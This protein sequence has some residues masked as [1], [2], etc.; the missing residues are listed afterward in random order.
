[1]VKTKWE[2]GDLGMGID[3][4]ARHPSEPSGTAEAKIKLE[5]AVRSCMRCMR[6][7]H[8]FM[9]WMLRKASE[10]QSRTEEKIPNFPPVVFLMFSDYN[11]NKER[12]VLY[13]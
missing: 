2:M 1:M 5:K 7:I 13:E 9:C 8:V 3:I 6:N 12:G 4:K 10:M 11:K